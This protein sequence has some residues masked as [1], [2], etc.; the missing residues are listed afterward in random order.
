MTMSCPKCK[1]EGKV[2]TTA[3]Q[4]SADLKK[5]WHH[6]WRVVVVAVLPFIVMGVATGLARVTHWMVG[7]STMV[8]VT[9]GPRTG[10]LEPS[11]G[12]AMIGMFSFV[13]AIATAVFT[14]MVLWN[15]KEP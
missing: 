12:M 2:P 4:A 13:A 1:G 11:W 3:E 14:S 9:Y 5:I 7:A 6:A 15:G 8:V 10:D